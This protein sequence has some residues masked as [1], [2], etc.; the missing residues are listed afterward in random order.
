MEDEWTKA[1]PKEQQQRSN[2][3][4]ARGKKRKKRKT[5]NHLKA[6]GWKGKG[7]SRMAIV[8]G[9][10]DQVLSVYDTIFFWIVY[11]S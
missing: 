2:D 10:E 9:C 11:N 7:R 8:G 6:K 4:G 5:K 1:G 3:L